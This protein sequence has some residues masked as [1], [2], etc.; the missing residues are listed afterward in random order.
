MGPVIRCVRRARVFE[1]DP[2]SFEFDA[3]ERLYFRPHIGDFPFPSIV[4]GGLDNVWSIFIYGRYATIYR[5]FHCYFFDLLEFS[6]NITW[7]SA[8]K[9]VVIRN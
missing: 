1:T 5:F 8:P 3:E 2:V 9:A 4:S 7:G 6:R